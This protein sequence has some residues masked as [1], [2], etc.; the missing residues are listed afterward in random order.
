[1]MAGA[2]DASPKVRRWSSLRSTW[3]ERFVAVLSA[4]GFINAGSVSKSLVA[5]VCKVVCPRVLHRAG[6]PM[7][8]ASASRFER[9]ARELDVRVVCSTICVEPLFAI[10]SA[11]AF[12]SASRCR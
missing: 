10:S 4:T 5:W 11:P 3:K 7:S 6:R 12:L 2:A 9:R 8:R 1:M